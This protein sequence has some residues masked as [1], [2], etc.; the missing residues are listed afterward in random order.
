ML[1]T[2][3]TRSRLP[4]FGRMRRAESA[5]QRHGDKAD[6]GQ[7][8]HFRYRLRAPEILELLEGSFDRFSDQLPQ[9]P[10]S[11][12]PSKQPDLLHRSQTDKLGALVHFE[13]QGLTST[14][15]YWTVHP[16]CRDQGLRSRGSS[17]IILHCT[18]PVKRFVLWVRADNENAVRRYVHFGYAPDGLVDNVLANQ[19][20]TNNEKRTRNFERD[21]A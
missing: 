18:R 21:P 6:C 11:K 15:R 20:I 13:T 4:A 8:G 16:E 17:G 19:L 10:K 2:Q 3:T 7:F 14:V 9:S 12:L 1:G 5:W